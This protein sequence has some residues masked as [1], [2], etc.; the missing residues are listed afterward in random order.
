MNNPNVWTMD[1]AATVH[2]M[3]H[4]VGLQ[5]PK[6]AS[7]TSD[8]VTMGNGADIGAKMIAQVPGVIC[9][10]HG[11]ELKGAVLNNVMHFPEAKYN[12][13]SLLRMMRYEGRKLGGDKEALWI[14]KD[15]Q[16][17]H[18][19]IV[20]LTLKGTLYCMY[21]KRV[22]EMA[23][24]ATESGTKINIMKAHDL[25][26]HCSEDM[27]HSAI[28]LMDWVLSGLWMPCESYAAAKAKQKNVPKE[29]EHE[30]AVKGENC[31]FLDIAMIKEA[32]D[33][34]PVSKPNW[35]IMVDERTGMKFSD[36]YALKVVMVEPTCEQWH[37]W[38]MVGLGIK[39]CRL[40][41]AGKKCSSR[42]VRVKSGKWTSNSS[43][44]PKTH[45]SRIIWLN[46]A[47]QYSQTEKGCS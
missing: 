24:T 43:S 15:R 27:T 39:Y 30:K 13:F 4:S 8:L 20:I 23:M 6:E 12:L 47:L 32:K 9:N 26:G 35:W 38:K 46:W 42:G 36:F 40:D 31:I 29:S 45:C 34:P 21:Y 1:K 7:S 3:L 22:T 33:G 10:K 44:Q 5:N 2:S 18:F 16:E 11:N 41:N 19:N 14:K 28:K 17:V 25:L 37:H